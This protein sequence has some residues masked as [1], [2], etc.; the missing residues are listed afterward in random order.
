MDSAALLQSAV[1]RIDR[2]REGEIGKNEAFVRMLEVNI[3]SSLMLAF[4]QI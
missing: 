4:G 3:C 1:E 2:S